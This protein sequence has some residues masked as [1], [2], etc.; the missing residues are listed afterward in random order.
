M[1]AC[2]LALGLADQRSLWLEAALKGGAE[3]DSASSLL[4]LVKEL[5][6]YRPYF[7][8]QTSLEPAENSICS[9]R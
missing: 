1:P 8:W 6:L 4:S 7:R 5:L 2:Q 9:V 3:W